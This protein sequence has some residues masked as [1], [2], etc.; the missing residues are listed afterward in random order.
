[1][2]DFKTDIFY[3]IG[4]Y[5]IFII[6]ATAHEAAH[7]WTA[8]RGG[9][10][11]AYAGGQVSLNPLPHIKREP[12]GMIVL[13]IISAIILGWPFGYASTPYNTD[14]A[15]QNPRKSAWMA[16]AGPA[17]NLIL[18]LFSVLVIRLGIL[19]G[20]FLEPYTI[21]FRHMMDASSGGIGETL[22]T[23][24]S[25]L[26]TMNLIMVVLNLF[27]LPPFDGSGVISFFLHDEAA[28]NYRKIIS[29]PLFGFVGFLIAWQVFSPLFDF[30]FVGVI[31][32]IYWRAGFA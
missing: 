30:I 10:L 8:K 11:T 21:N 13:P 1:M 15:N 32:T 28:R 3:A 6:S 22:V 25:M 2:S 7:A 19:G 26:F 9:D 23:F 27:P 4:W 5:I 20:I 14:W 29:N 31:N 12:I 16:V 24:I 18:V 17:A